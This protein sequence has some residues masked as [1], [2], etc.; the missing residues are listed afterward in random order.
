VRK[1]TPQG[2]KPGLLLGEQV[3]AGRR[4]KLG[5]NGAGDSGRL[6]QSEAP[7]K[8]PTRKEIARYYAGQKNMF[9]P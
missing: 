7:V 5:E 3:R 2:R 6:L 1:K 9:I 8:K 4:S